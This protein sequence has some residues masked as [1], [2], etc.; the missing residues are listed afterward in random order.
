MD[1]NVGIAPKPLNG[2]TSQPRAQSYADGQ[3]PGS[4]VRPPVSTTVPWTQADNGL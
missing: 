4:N 2:G 3:T 1:M